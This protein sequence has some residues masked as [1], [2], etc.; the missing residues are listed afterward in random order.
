[1]IIILNPKKSNYTF[2]IP[3]YAEN[4]REREVIVTVSNFDKLSN[5]SFSFLRLTFFVLQNVGMFFVYHH[6]LDTV[7]PRKEKISKL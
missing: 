4:E 3:N 6:A 2:Q 7:V 1:M 5:G